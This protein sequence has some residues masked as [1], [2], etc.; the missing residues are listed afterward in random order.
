VRNLPVADK[1]ELMLWTVEM[2]AEFLGVGVV[3]VRRLIQQGRLYA[4]RA[5]KRI[6]LLNRV[7][8]QEFKKL[9]GGRPKLSETQKRDF[10]IWKE[11]GAF[12]SWMATCAPSLMP[13]PCCVC[14]KMVGTV[15]P[16]GAV[17][18]SVRVAVKHYPKVPI[19]AVLRTGRKVRGRCPGSGMA[20]KGWR[21]KEEPVGRF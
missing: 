18:W 14:G 15:V 10:E 3:R 1:N 5:G 11:W 21:K 17:G 9:S 13:G 16:N 8:V 19:A 7:N 6:L 4:V 2:A 20:P 12:D